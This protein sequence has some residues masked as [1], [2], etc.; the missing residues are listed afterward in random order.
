MKTRYVDFLI[1]GTAKVLQRK[2]K[3][4]T[5]FDNMYD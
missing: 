1:E 3:Y 2:A 4:S 5:I